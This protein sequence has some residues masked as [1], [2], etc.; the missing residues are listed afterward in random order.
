M[1]AQHLGVGE[2]LHD[3]ARRRV[4]LLGAPVSVGRVL[5][6]EAR[7]GCR[8]RREV[9]VVS[10][11]DLWTVWSRENCL[12]AQREAPHAREIERRLATLRCRVPTV[13]LAFLLRPRVLPAGRCLPAPL[14]RFTVPMNEKKS[15]KFEPLAFDE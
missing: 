3:E 6:E 11:G 9:P 2:D 14:I 7:L 8:H 4:A 13:S 15:R 12:P 1:T 10:D 5:N